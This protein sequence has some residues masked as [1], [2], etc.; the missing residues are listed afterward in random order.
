MKKVLIVAFIALLIE[1]VG[2][3]AWAGTISGTIKGSDG[4][5]FRAAFVR[6]KHASPRQTDPDSH[7]KHR[8]FPA[9]R[10]VRAKRDITT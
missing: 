6:A 5:A 1:A 10:R 7:E 8:R 2:P 9:F 4:T 3:A